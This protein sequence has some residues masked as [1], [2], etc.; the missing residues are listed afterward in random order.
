MP[1]KKK[2]KVKLGFP[3][4]FKETE[5]AL[6]SGEPEP[7]GFDAELKVVGTRVP[8]VDGPDK[9]SGRAR[10]TFDL[11]LPGMLHATVLR[12]PHPHARLKRIDL[13]KVEAH[14][15]V[16][17][18]LVMEEKEYRFAGVEV[19][20]VAATTLAAA[21][22]AL[23]LIEIEY[24]V[25]PFVTDPEKARTVGAPKVRK[26]GNR[27]VSADKRRGDL[28]AGFRKADVEVEVRV[29]TPVALHACLEGHGSLARWEGDH[30]TV[31]DSTQ[32]VFDVRDSLAAALKHPPAKVRIIKDHAG[33]GFGSKLQMWT[34]TPIAARLAKLANAPVKLLLSRHEDFLCTG[35]RHSSVQ[36]VRLA[37]RRDG[38]FTALSWDSYGTGGVE[39]GAETSGPI[40]GMYRVP[41][42][43]IHEEDVYTN[44]GP[45][46]AMR[47]PGHVQG[48]VALE[49]AID[50]L[51]EKVC[52]DPLEV[53]LLNDKSAIR[54]AEL[55]LGAERIG[56]SRRRPSGSDRGALKR[57]LGVAGTTW[58]GSGLP[59]PEVEVTL[60]ADG[61][62][63]V[64]CCTQDIGTGTRTILAQVVAEEL[65]VPV[66]EVHVYLGD[67][68]FPYSI[69]SGGSLTA[70][71][72]TP[73]ARAAAA[74]LRHALLKL[75]SG[76]LET[77]EQAL[78]IEGRCVCILGRG[79][80]LP[81]VE[82]LQGTREKL[83]LKGVHLDKQ[84]RKLTAK[85]QRQANYE[86]FESGA[87][88]CQFV[89]V[90]VDTELGKVRVLRVVAVHDSGRILNPLLWE[91]Q[92][93]GGIIQGISFAL[94]EQRVMD[95]RYGRMLN[96]DLETYKVLGALEI[97]AIEIIPFPVAAGFNNTQVV[98]IGEPAIIPTAAAV[99]NAVA[100]ALG[101]RIPDLPITPDKVLDALASRGEGAC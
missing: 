96:A 50:E 65:R 8:R 85:A 28:D 15:E 63:E 7:W 6:V 79:R 46:C 42:V 92:V 47:A 9:V 76:P 36:R 18:V 3:G 1:T 4:H 59:G 89:E 23:R 60:E 26:E 58:D 72:V 17:A 54:K 39:S 16:R 21:H 10:Y 82:V 51:S 88:G 78:D 90:E 71:C 56:W 41:A 45:A 33:G 83:S 20:A 66:E 75:A 14:P 80:S 29:T 57:G 43:G 13:S 73:A 61:R 101:F 38:A 11:S 44:A 84:T 37:A 77:D 2:A 22:E 99:A 35:N 27:D 100:N 52:L 49:A 94:L 25:L 19:A 93:N 32:A 74:R 86:G 34:H 12:C 69:L 81:W 67:S 53:R 68:Y 87:A 31:W 30:L 5:V 98:G 24:E 95:H 55:R 40:E 48:M 97:P 64:F 70:A 91:S 62:I